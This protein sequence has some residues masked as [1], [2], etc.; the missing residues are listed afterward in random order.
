MTTGNSGAQHE[1]LPPVVSVGPACPQDDTHEGH[2]ES[3]DSRWRWTWALPH[4][5]ESS[6]L[7]CFLWEASPT[8]HT[9]RADSGS[10]RVQGPLSK[11]EAHQSAAP[12]P[13][14]TPTA[15]SGPAVHGQG[16]S[17]SPNCRQS[18]RGHTQDSEEA[19]RSSESNVTLLQ[20]SHPILQKDW[21]A[22]SW[23]A[24]RP[25]LQHSRLSKHWEAGTRISKLQLSS[26]SG[27]RTSQNQGACK[28]FFSVC[29]H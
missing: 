6:T 25:V 28:H 3:D 19:P 18:R 13:C 7:G 15:D 11:P 2:P 10:V 24:Q 20:H 29:L 27:F 17:W 9:D 5:H 21:S 16:C 26:G 8:G 12:Q 23:G 14:P 22:T 1:F 4:E